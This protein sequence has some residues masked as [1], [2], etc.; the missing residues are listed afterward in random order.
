MKRILGNKLTLSLDALLAR[1]IAVLMLLALS[2]VASAAC[3]GDG[4]QRPLDQIGSDAR[5]VLFKRDYA[6]LDKLAADFRDKNALASDGQ[7]KLMGFYAGLSKSDTTC[8]GPEESDGQWEWYRGLLSAWSKAV[9]DS[10]AAKLALAKFEAAYAWKARG[11]GYASTVT[12][13][14][15]IQF[16]KRMSNARQMLEELAPMAT[17]EP[18]W[19]ASMLNIAV[20]QGWEAEKFDALYQQAIK[21]FPYYL[22]LYFIKGSF[23]SAKWHG[24]KTEFKAFVEEAVKATE[25]QWGQTMYARLH[26]S[27]SDNF[28]FKNGKTDWRRMRLGFEKM[29]KDFPDNWNLNNFAKFAC[30][31]GDWKTL[32]QQLDLIGNNAVIGA[33]GDTEY[34]IA[35]KS[36][37]DIRRKQV[38]K[39]DLQ[40][41]RP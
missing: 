16:R 15:W 39:G 3:G 17:N 8:R 21:K 10:F 34:F 27:E 4:Q 25:S 29:L 35:C 19:Y 24:S 5:L 33:W 1:L 30:M 26:W 36:F 32:G 20:A 18:E 11:S 6:N 37:S 38:S 2:N 9:P 13:A 22:Q 31:A 28:M 23:Y 12:E 40:N 14:G 7:P 41:A